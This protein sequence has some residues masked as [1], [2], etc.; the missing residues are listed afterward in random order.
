M[1]KNILICGE[2]LN[3]GGVETAI[4]NEALTLK[5][6]GY[7]VY[8]LAEKGIYTRILHEAGIENI[9]FK[10]EFTNGFDLEKTGKIIDI[11]KEKEINEAHIHK[12]ISIPSC[13]PAFIIT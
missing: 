11:I 10:M 13:L 4:V 6:M 7:N 5:K 2:H 9:D 12:F 1:K 3:D 8:V